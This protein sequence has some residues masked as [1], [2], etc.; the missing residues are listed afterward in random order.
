M[1]SMIVAYANGRVIGRKGRI[2]WHLP[3]D[4]QHFRRITEGHTVVMGRRT[5]ESIGKP[6]IHRRNVVLTTQQGYHPEGVEVVHS[7]D[8]VLALRDVFVIGGASLYR[9][10]LDKTSLLYITEIALEVEGDTHFP[11][12]SRQDFILVSSQDGVC[13]ESNPYPHTFSLYQRRIVLPEN[14]SR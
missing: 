12:W 7:P 2:P 14:D 13:N 10:F 8:D 9:L 11:E 3:S 4:M 6:L 1:I 5:F